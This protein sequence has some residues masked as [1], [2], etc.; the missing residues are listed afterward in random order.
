MYNY[1]CIFFIK[2]FIFNF[3]KNDIEANCAKNDATGHVG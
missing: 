1:L 3:K 2:Y